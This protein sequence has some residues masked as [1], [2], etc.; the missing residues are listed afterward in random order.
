MKK[1]KHLKIS[2]LQQAI[3]KW[4]YQILDPVSA[5]PDSKQ[6]S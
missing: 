2:D 6:L 5:N 3:T 1:L 4:Q